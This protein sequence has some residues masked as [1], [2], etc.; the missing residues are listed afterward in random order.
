MSQI[1]RPSTQITTVSDEPIMLTTASATITDGDSDTATAMGNDL[2]QTDRR[3]SESGLSG[4]RIKNKLIIRDKISPTM[5]KI[6][7]DDA[8]D[9][10]LQRDNRFAAGGY[11]FLREALDFTVKML[12][13]A[14]GARLRAVGQARQVGKTTAVG[15]ADVYLVDGDD[16]TPCGAVLASGRVIRAGA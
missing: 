1:S 9:N 10:I 11:H 5:Q 16:L 6:G 12:G 15:A 14:K 2:F 13:V 4:A 3:V 8:I 7:F